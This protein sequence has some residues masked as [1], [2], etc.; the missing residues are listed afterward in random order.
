ML[1][2][3]W[4][5]MPNALGIPLPNARCTAGEPD[6][7][8]RA[9]TPVGEPLLSSLWVTHSMSIG[10]AYIM[11][12]PSYNLLGLLLSLWVQGI[13]FDSFQ[14]ILPIVVQQLVVILVFA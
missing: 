12:V 2:P 8:F 4:S 5:S 9:L 10:F 11:K 6:L 7:E 3:C 1:M 13:F 14:S